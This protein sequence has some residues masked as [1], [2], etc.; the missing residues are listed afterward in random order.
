MAI[1]REPL[2]FTRNAEEL[3]G[4][5]EAAEG[6][7]EDPASRPPPKQ[8]LPKPGKTRLGFVARHGSI[9]YLEPNI[10]DSFLVELEQKMARLEQRLC[11]KDVAQFARIVDQGGIAA[12]KED[13]EVYAFSNFFF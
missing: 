5:L 9:R 3:D 7:S 10:Y 1:P 6:L 2:A 8:L 4:D 12:Y 13:P 11:P